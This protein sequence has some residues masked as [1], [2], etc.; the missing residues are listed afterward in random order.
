M[1]TVLWYCIMKCYMEGGKNVGMLN[2]V[3]I[4]NQCP[5]GDQCPT[6]GQWPTANQS[7]T[8]D[9]WPTGN[10]CPTGDQCPMFLNT[11]ALCL[12]YWTHNVELK[13]C[14]EWWCQNIFHLRIFKRLLLKFLNFETQLCWCFWWQW[15][16]PPVACC[17]Y[18]NT[19]KSARYFILSVILIYECDMGQTDMWL[20]DRVPSAKL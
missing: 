20:I 11:N 14:S 16:C 8:G 18:W 1:E 15:V 5:M 2:I 7:P 12:I 13:K 10:Q 6:G 17:S 19:R 9:Q 3:P 4:G